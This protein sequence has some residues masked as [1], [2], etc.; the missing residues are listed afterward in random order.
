MKKLLKRRSEIIR[1]LSDLSR[2]E[3][4]NARSYDYLPLERELDEINRQLG[5]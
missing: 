1:T 5:Q 2:N 4:Q 3:W